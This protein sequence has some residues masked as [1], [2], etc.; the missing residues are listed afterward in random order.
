MPDPTLMEA[1]LLQAYV[2]L[3]H[4]ASELAELWGEDEGDDPTILDA[5]AAIRATGL[6][7]ENI[8]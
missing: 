2:A 4:A 3:T 5:L 1:A 7:L 8:R 6:G